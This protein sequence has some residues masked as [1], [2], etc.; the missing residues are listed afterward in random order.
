[1]RIFIKKLLPV[2]LAVVL[3][4]GFAG[5]H[6]RTDGKNPAVS[7]SPKTSAAPSGSPMAS[8]SPGANE[9]ES[10][11]G[12][13]SPSGSPMTSG[14]PSDMIEGFM[15]GVV[16]DPADAPFA[17][18]TLSRHADYKDL[19][20]QSITYKLYEERQAYCVIL[21]GEGD[22]SIRVYVFPDGKVIPA[23]GEN[24]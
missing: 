21:Q 9:T 4:A 3:I 11:M 15:E 13:A 20:I 17:V 12:S 16:V 1:M 7:N 5:C 24:G 2:L 14:N 23:E 19:A 18:E 22:A 8:A 6:A 10:P